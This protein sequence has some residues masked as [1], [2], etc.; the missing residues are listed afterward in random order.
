[1]HQ[2]YGLAGGLPG[3][4]SSNL[5]FRSGG[6]LERLPPM[7][8]ATLQ[9]GDVFHHRMPGGG[10]WGDPLLRDPEAV[11]RDVRDEKVTRAAAR[12]LYAVDVRE[13]GTVDGS[14]T[15]ELRGARRGA[16]RIAEQEPA[17]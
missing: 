10:G 4:R 6:S 16:G 7:F 1:V 13:D 2:P 9:P 11:A 12:E 14:V 17:L 8:G 5:I 3:G 15:A